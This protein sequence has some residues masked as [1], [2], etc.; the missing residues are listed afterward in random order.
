MLH[1]HTVLIHT[2]GQYEYFET[3]VHNEYMKILP[4]CVYMKIIIDLKVVEGVNKN[5]ILASNNC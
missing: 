4:N 3:C 2:N 5:G 1:F